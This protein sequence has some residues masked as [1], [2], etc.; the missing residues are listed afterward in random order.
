MV[1]V[2]YI[3]VNSPAVPRVYHLTTYVE[4]GHCLPRH[5]VTPPKLWVL[6]YRSSKLMHINH[7]Q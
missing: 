4:L 6:G 7:I 3:V 1:G 2:R 5:S